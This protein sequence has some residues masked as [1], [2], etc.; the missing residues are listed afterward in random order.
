MILKS[1]ENWQD[2]MSGEQGVAAFHNELFSKLEQK[3]FKNIDFSD[4]RHYVEENFHQYESDEPSADVFF[5]ELDYE[6]AGKTFCVAYPDLMSELQLRMGVLPNEEMKSMFSILETAAVLKGMFIAA[7]AEPDMK[8]WEAGNLSP[9][10]QIVSYSLDMPDA[11]SNS[12]D[13]IHTLLDVIRVAITPTS[14]SIKEVTAMLD[15]LLNRPAASR[16]QL[17]QCALAPFGFWAN[18]RLRIPVSMHGSAIVTD[19]GFTEDFLSL[20]KVGEF[21]TSTTPP[22]RERHGACPALH[23]AFS[24]FDLIHRLGLL[25]RD[26][27]KALNT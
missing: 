25:Y 24:E 12:Q 27:F 17:E 5:S 4:A 19:Q 11:K 2:A 3:D 21:E 9:G 18:A 26:L 23:P 8:K 16:S 7:A 1:A 13:N 22:I 10:Q 14:K 20:I 6:T 15:T